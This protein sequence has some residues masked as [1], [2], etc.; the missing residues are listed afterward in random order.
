MEVKYTGII[1]LKP[2]FHLSLLTQQRRQ[3]FSGEGGPSPL[4][5]ITRFC[6]GS[7]AAASRMVMKF[8]G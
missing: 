4:M 8:N 5:A 6:R 3:D 1:I 7:M 2:P